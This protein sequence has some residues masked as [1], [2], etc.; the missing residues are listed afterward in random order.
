MLDGEWWSMDDRSNNKIG[1]F[2][3][4]FKRN[5]GKL[6]WILSI[7]Q[8]KS[9]DRMSLSKFALK[10]IHLHASSCST[11]VVRRRH[12]FH[13]YPE[14]RQKSEPSY[15][16]AT[17]ISHWET[18]RFCKWI[19]H[20]VNSDGDSEQWHPKYFFVYLPSLELNSIGLS[21]SFLAANSDTPR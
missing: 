19:G 6:E 10:L 7:N 4:T 15:L 21:L 3:K 14:L 13:L 2:R 18:W 16:R 20:C 8:P 1:S 5:F 17:D 11:T 12:P 9:A